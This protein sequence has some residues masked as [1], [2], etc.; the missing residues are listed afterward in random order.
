MSEQ[1]Y[2]SQPQEEGQYYDQSHNYPPSNYYQQNQYTQQQDKPPPT[3]TAG[4]PNEEGHFTQAQPPNLQS[5]SL[6]LPQYHSIIPEERSL[7]QITSLEQLWNMP[8][9]YNCRPTWK[10]WFILLLE[11]IVLLIVGK[12]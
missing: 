5:Q 9:F 12:Y 7:T 4:L 8:M 2:Q 3:G 11:L 6:Q 1:V 10:F